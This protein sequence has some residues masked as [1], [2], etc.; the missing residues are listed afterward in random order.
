MQE[1]VAFR[2]SELK[3]SKREAVG[4]SHSVAL[5]PHGVISRVRAAAQEERTSEM[6]LLIPTKAALFTPERQFF[7]ALRTC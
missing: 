7:F 5:N 1:D 6:S 2:A 4:Q 3:H